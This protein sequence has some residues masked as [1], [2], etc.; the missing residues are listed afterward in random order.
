M[1]LE[2]AAS[3]LWNEKEKKK[4]GGREGKREYSLWQQSNAWNIWLLHHQDN[5]WSYA[6]TQI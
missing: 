4:G 1:Y 3:Y 2:E 6:A 5:S